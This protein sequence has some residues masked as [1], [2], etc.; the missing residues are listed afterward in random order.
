MNCPKCGF[1][2]NTDATF[3]KKCGYNL[4]E[5]K[6]KINRFNDQINIL[7]VS[8]GLIVSIIFLFIGAAGFIGVPNSGIPLAAYVVLVFFVV[9]FFGALVT[10][11]LGCETSKDG[12][13]NGLFLNLIILIGTAFLLAVFAFIT[14][15][16]TAVISSAF[17]PLA[18][19]SSALTA[20]TTA[21]T[22][23][24]V[25]TAASSDGILQ[26]LLYIL[27]FIASIVLVLVAG[28]LGGSF[29][30]FI[31]KGIRNL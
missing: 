11:F 22:A 10:G 31:R 12:I 28:A 26:L 7:A 19:S 3:C 8:L 21:T 30:V 18:S 25:T 29:G 5:N 6:S 24:D 16:I 23:S 9:A 1:N 27:E 2:N 15:G 14:S 4:N 20:S 17:A 13:I